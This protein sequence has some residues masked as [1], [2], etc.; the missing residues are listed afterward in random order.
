VF[1]VLLFFIQWVAFI[2]F[3]IYSQGWRRK[4]LIIAEDLSVFLRWRGRKVW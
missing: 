1:D 3:F 4:R 2:I